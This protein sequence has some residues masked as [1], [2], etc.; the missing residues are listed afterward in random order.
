MLKSRAILWANGDDSASISIYGNDDTCLRLRHIILP[1]FTHS[2]ALNI[3]HQSICLSFCPHI[4]TAADFWSE[5]VTNNSV[6]IRNH[7]GITL[8][9]T[10]SSWVSDPRLY[11]HYQIITVRPAILS[12]IGSAF[13]GLLAGVRLGVNRKH[14][15]D[16]HT[17]YRYEY[18]L[19]RP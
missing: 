11:C 1:T 8:L 10:D 13:G 14:N 6:L 18:N 4:Y 2:S 9:L 5:F 12:R 15:S 7:D 3:S 19:I 17:T 16:V